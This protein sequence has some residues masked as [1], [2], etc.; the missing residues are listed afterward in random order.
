MC[1][2]VPDPEPVASAELAAMRVEYGRSPLIDETVL[3]AGWE[4]LLRQWIADAMTA[5]VAEPNAMVLATV[6]TDGLP[7]ARTVLC[8]E[9]NADGVVFFTNYDSEKGRQ[10]AAK[11]YAALTFAWPAVYRQVHLRGPVRQVSTAETL[12][13]WRSR[14]RG[15]QLGAWASRQSS[16]VASRAALEQAL[17]DA[18]AR[19]AG[20]DD[21]PVAPHWGGY[22]VSARLVEFWQGRENRLH[23]R[24]RLDLGTDG[25]WT[26]V[27]LQP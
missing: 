10:L 8:K 22:Q 20:V 19:F 14:P 4:P 11:P 12:E 7:A 2:I 9:L 23:N 16:A 26:A 24:I 17:T 5:E 6:D 21:I 1:E 15:S 18:E 27:R 25:N 3:R 13:Y